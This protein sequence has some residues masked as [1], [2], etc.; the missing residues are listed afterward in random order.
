MEYLKQFK[1]HVEEDNLPSA[2]ALWQEYCL[3]DEVDPEEMALILDAV[4]GAPFAKSFGIYAEEGLELWNNLAPSD[5]KNEVL[6]LIFD[7]Q[8]ANTPKLAQIAL[9]YLTTKYGKLEIFPEVLRIVGLRDKEDFQG[10]I[11]NFELLI[12]LQKG[13]FCFHTGS[14][15]V[16]EVMDIS[17]LRREISIEFDLVSDVK[18]ISFKNAFNT[19]LPISADHFLARRFGDPVK[20]EAYTRAN[21]VDAI[22]LLLKDLGDKTAFDIKEEMEGVVIAE[23][24][25]T[26]WWNTVRAKLKKDAEIEYPSSVKL[27]FKLCRKKVSHEDR[28]KQILS[29]E[30]NIDILI[31]ELYE[32]FR[33][34]TSLLKSA[35]FNSYLKG[36]I[37][38]LLTNR[39]VSESQRLQLLFLLE[40]LHDGSSADIAELIKNNTDIISL[41]NNIDIL[42]YKRRLLSKLKK[43]RA[44]FIKIFCDIIFLNEKNS[45][46]DFL[47]DEIVLEK[48]QSEFLKRLEEIVSDPQKSPHAFIWYFQMVIKNKVEDLVDQKSLEKLFEAFFVLMYF[49]EAGLKDKALTKK[50]FLMLTEK[51]FEIVRRI[52][53]GANIETIE[54]LLL[55]ATKCQIL[56]SH[57]IKILY[58]LAEVVHPEIAKGKKGDVDQKEEEVL[59]TTAEGLKKVTDRIEEIAVKET[60][61]N[62]KEIEIAR[63]YGDLREN[64]EY[65]FA[66]E[67]RARLQSEM[68]TLSNQVKRMR[69]LTKE[70]IDT[71][72][73]SVGTKVV[74]KDEKNQRVEYSILGPFDADPEKNILS[75]QSKLALELIGKTVGQKI[76]AGDNSWVVE[77]ITSII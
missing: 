57:D 52:F 7:L 51:R 12:H 56:S 68:K 63:S 4:R 40:D 35:S 70:D 49:V 6:K 1:K 61:D 39:K 32:F 15:G 67:K 27:P 62:A 59:W 33:D 24:E 11:R 38:G 16:G 14:W 77:K 36:E 58:S 20:F 72:K 75:L 31:G 18:E 69:I 45:L 53:K 42:A 25:W 5:A 34:F 43:I 64:S 37:S 26:K 28:L 50:M 41:V 10:C 29:T 22:K 48:K 55:L 76:I 9:N 47:F 73:I 19:L 8:T 13:N 21:P 66:M 46:R 17:F 60:M 65:K 30:K 54:E 2:V 44:D 23:E 3:S 74:L 71:S